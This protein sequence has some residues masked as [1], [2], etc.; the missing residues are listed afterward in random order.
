MNKN[1]ENFNKYTFH[2]AMQRKI[3]MIMT[4]NL[5]LKAIS[6]I[7]LEIYQQTQHV[8]R[9]GL[10]VIGKAKFSGKFSNNQQ[11]LT[12]HYSAADNSKDAIITRQ[13]IVFAV[14][15]CMVVFSP[16]HVIITE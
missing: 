12:K 14:I 2:Y 9:H 3:I 13:T 1:I 8:Y 15:T 16:H 11:F 7:C 4:F 5:L 6:N 10:E